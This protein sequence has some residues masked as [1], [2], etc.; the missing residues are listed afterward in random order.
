MYVFYLEVYG[1]GGG[2]AIKE[3]CI[4]VIRELLSCNSKRLRNFNHLALESPGDLM[5]KH[6][7]T[8]FL[9]ARVSCIHH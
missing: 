1:G 4:L 5:G 2:V 3:R 7:E 8:S 9:R 6:S